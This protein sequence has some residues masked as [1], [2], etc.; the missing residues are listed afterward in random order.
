MEFTKLLAAATSPSLIWAPVL[1]AWAVATS[2]R[3]SLYEEH[4]L[5]TDDC[6]EIVALHSSWLNGRTARVHNVL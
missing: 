2:L 5:P 1:V 6:A 3:A 4:F